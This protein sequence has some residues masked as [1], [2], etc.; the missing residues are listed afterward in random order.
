VYYD[1]TQAA[2]SWLGAKTYPLAGGGSLMP[3]P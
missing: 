1:A 2:N 3:V